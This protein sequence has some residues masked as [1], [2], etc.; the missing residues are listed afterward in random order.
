MLIITTSIVDHIQLKV[1]LRMKVISF[2]RRTS[3]FP[4]YNW[5][6]S[7]VLCY[8]SPLSRRFSRTI[9]VEWRGE[10]EDRFGSANVGTRCPWWVLFGCKCGRIPRWCGVSWRLGVFWAVHSLGSGPVRRKCCHRAVSS[11]NNDRNWR[12]VL[13][14]FA[15]GITSLWVYRRSCFRFG[16]AKAR[17]WF[18]LD[19]VLFELRERVVGF[20]IGIVQT[21]KDGSATS[22]LFLSWDHCCLPQQEW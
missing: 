10:Q 20:R 12:V 16:T 3:W 22:N 7:L 1:Y 15:S 2:Q 18:G 21:G 6:Q 14:W 9:E 4:W 19:G 13:R 8:N 11:Y 5:Q 17:Q